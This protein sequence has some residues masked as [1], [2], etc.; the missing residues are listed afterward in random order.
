MVICIL[1]C[2][3]KR[4]EKK[5]T[6]LLNDGAFATNTIVP[7]K[8]KLPTISILNVKE[9]SSN[10]EFIEKVKN[11]N[12]KIKQLI[13][14]GSEFSVVYCRKPKET[15]TEDEVNKYFQIVVRVS[16]E[17]RQ[18]IRS[19]NNKL[20]IELESY[21]VVDRFY[22]KRCNKC[23]GFGHYERDCENNE[24]CGYCSEAHLS[25]QCTKV[26]H[27]DHRNF[28]CVN[29]KD[30]GEFEFERIFSNVA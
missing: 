8:S 24:R 21:R 12:P 27:H 10:G 1:I 19:N 6:P 29:C 11:Q 28:N 15:E 2:Q 25:N 7:L 26:E 3:M 9:F 16:G 18:A 20:Y 22:I 17:I 14:A 23:Q 5:L 13:D 4:T 30:A